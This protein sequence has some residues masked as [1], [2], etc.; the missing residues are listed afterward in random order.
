MPSNFLV[1][2]ASL[3]LLLAARCAMAEEP[4]A[5]DHSR[6]MVYWTADGQEH[7]VQTAADWAIRRRQIIAG[8]EKVMGKLPDRSKLPPLDVKVIER[9]ERDSFIRLGITY[10]GADNARIP[11]H[12]YLPK[13]RP[14]GRHVAA[15]LAL[16]QTSSRGKKEVSGEDGAPANQAYGKELAER[17]YV[18]LAPDYPSFG[19]YFPDFH[20]SQFASGS[21][22]GVFNHMRGVDLL[23]A[24]EEV[25]PARIGAIGH[26]LGGHNAM[27]VG[28][29]DQRLKVIVSSCGWTPFHDY[30]GGKLAGW[31]QDRY[32]PRIRDVYGLNADR[33]PFDFYEVV[34]AFAPRAFFSNSPL[35]DYNFEVKGVKK[36]EV[37]A[38]EVYALLG[39]ADRLQIRYP[40][41]SHDFP[42][43]IR[44][45]AYAF[46][47]RILGHK[48]SRNVPE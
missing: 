46:I 33:V 31:V 45:E 13:D 25:D 38:R 39:A 17:G 41:C 48:P 21:M 43:A 8:M 22:M 16:H 32:M 5:V 42:P 20:K 14:A 23:Q 4:A 40:Q 1:V 7:P 34:A 6:L 28:A 24:R 26:S 27:F 35:G 19:D 36:A 30:Y 18:V 12:L 29:F 10:L 44:R 11:A 37:K 47:D 2:L 15:M 9:V 3:A